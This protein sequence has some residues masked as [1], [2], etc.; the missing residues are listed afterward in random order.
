MDKPYS[1]NLVAVYN[2]LA[3]DTTLLNVESIITGEATAAFVVAVGSVG[4]IVN[5]VNNS[6]NDIGIISFFTQG[7]D[8]LRSRIAG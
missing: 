6:P 1:C 2:S 4:I 8:F 7:L 3:A 5:E